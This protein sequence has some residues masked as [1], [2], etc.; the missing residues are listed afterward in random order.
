MTFPH[1]DHL[2]SLQEAANIS[3][4]SEIRLREL[5]NEGKIRA[6]VLPGGEIGVSRE[7]A[8]ITALNERLQTISREQFKNLRGKSISATDGAQ[9]YDLHRNTI[10]KWAKQRYIQVLTSGYR[11]EVDEADLA[12]CV[13][14]HNERKKGYGVQT[15]APLL[16][17]NGQP[18]LIKN[19]KL[20]DY[21][22]RKKEPATPV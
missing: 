1:L 21:R 15:G 14:I 7:L 3:G 5:I 8:A 4:L 18:Y 22:R 17:K 2:I 19:P 13:A 16:D 10:I 12:Y 11:M 20:S 9:K 6:A